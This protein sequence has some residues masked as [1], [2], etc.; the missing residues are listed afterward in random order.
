MI[1]VDTLRA[2]H[3]SSS[4]Y[5]RLT[6]PFIDQLA[7]KGVRFTHAFVNT[8]G[9]PPS[10]TTMFTSLSQETHR[11][12]WVARA[13]ER[14]DH[15]APEE[16][17]TLAEV[18]RDAGYQTLAVT[19]GGFLGPKFGLDQGFDRFVSRRRLLDKIQAD[20]GIVWQTETLVAEFRAAK[21]SSSG[22]VFAFLHTYEV[23]SPYQSP[24]SYDDLFGREPR[25]FVA[26]SANLKAVKG[27]VRKTLSEG[28]LTSIVADYDRGIR[29]MDDALREMFSR[30][31]AQGFLDNTV[32]VLTSDHGEE[33]GEH[34]GLLHPA[35]LYDELLHVPL[36]VVGPN[37]ESG[38]SDPRM[39]ST[40]DL[41]PTILDLVGVEVPGHMQGFPLFDSERTWSDDAVVISQFGGLLY[42]VRSPRWK[43]IQYG[44]GATYLFDL[45]RDPRENHDVASLHPEVVSELMESL[46]IWRSRQSSPGARVKTLDDKL[47]PEE[48]KQLEALGYL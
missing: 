16:L 8:H 27:N 9:T 18:M 1:S 5:P 12:S 25:E 2:D 41:A 33:F 45:Y 43:L 48:L 44:K 13:T 10:H 34:G 20:K 24:A 32:V 37:L 26:T 40:L 42:S 31:E 23:H 46:R 29:Y 35:S 7:S 47:D 14:P 30:L 11:V 3:L 4:G 6:S 17:V 39:V 15:V 19:G 28:E 22:P 38:V 21:R 36:I